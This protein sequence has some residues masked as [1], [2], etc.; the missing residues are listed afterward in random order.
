MF[1]SWRWVTATTSPIAPCCD[2]QRGGA[3]RRTPAP[4]L[5]HGQLHARLVGRL[6]DAARRLEV[7]RERLLGEH[8]LAR[9]DRLQDQRR[10]LGR[11]RG[12]V[13][14]R[15]LGIGEHL[16]EAAVD[17]PHEREALAHAG[18]RRRQR[19]VDAGDVD[20][21]RLVGREVEVLRRGA[22]ADDRDGER[23]LRGRRGGSRAPPPAAPRRSSSA[24][25]RAGSATSGCATSAVGERRPRARSRDPSSGSAPGRARARRR[26]RGRGRDR[27]A[28]RPS[29]C[30]R[31]CGR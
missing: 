22:A 30:P 26:C 15:H 14:D 7:E 16:V 29:A 21:P 6:D 27:A 1:L 12:D 28:S 2:E 4:V 9:L 19:V 24:A 25:H 20:V 10:P 8:V 17:P 23:L 5:V 18:R 3:Q 13:D 11:A 31:R